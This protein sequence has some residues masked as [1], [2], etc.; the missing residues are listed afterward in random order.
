MKLSEFIAKLQKQ[1]EESGDLDVIKV[2]TEYE[3]G[4]EETVIAVTENFVVTECLDGSVCTTRKCEFMASYNPV[5]TPDEKAVRLRE[6]WCNEAV[7]VCSLGMTTLT[8]IYD[9]LLSGDLPV[10][11]KGE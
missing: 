7:G 1:L 9:A 4:K 3:N 11:G 5:E 10:P 8:R 6:E 2:N